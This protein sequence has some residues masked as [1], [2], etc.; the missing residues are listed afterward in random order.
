MGS[1]CTTGHKTPPAPSLEWKVGKIVSPN[2][3]RAWLWNVGHWLSFPGDRL[4]IPAYFTSLNNIAGHGSRRR[5]W[6]NRRCTKHHGD[7]RTHRLH[8][9]GAAFPHWLPRR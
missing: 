6:S 1:P 4:I 5:C 9:R 7:H 2:F 3:F 8:M